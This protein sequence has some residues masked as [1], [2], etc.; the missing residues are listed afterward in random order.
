MTCSPR[1]IPQQQIFKGN[2]VWDLPDLHGSGAA[3]KA[4]GLI[5]NDWQLSGV[6]TG[7]TG[8][9]LHRRPTATRAAAAR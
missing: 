6:W 4:V 8:Q 7:A 5:V 3:V 1:A 2:F 9:R